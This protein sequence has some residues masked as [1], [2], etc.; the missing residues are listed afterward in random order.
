MT[1]H[2]RPLNLILLGPPGAGKSTI[3]EALAHQHNLAVIAT[4]QRL[5][6][7][8][9]AQS[10]L[11]RA[12]EAYLENG[13]LAPDALIE[14]L[15]R[16]SLESLAP[17][18]GFLLDGYPRTQHQARGLADMLADY[19]RV[20]GAVIALDVAD[21]EVIRRLSG[22]RICE[23]AG[24]P[25]PLQIDDLEGIRRCQQGGGRLVHRDDDQPEVVQ[26][27]LAIYH[28]ETQPLLELYASAGLLRHVDAGGPAAEVVQRALAVLSTTQEP[29]TEDQEPKTEGIS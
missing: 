10:E 3:A 20:L 29:K 15:L 21:K 11:G 8:V 17:Q 24:D 25:H 1:A 26:Q 2:A 27:R 6:A 19:N 5:R 14:R 28:Q 18:Q 12:V 23:G 7:E 16:A 13:D 22:R 9:H 4:G